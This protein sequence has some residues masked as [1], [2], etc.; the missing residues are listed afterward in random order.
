MDSIYVYFVALPGNVNEMV[1][2]C[3]DGYT[4][5]IDVSLSRAEQLDAYRHAMAHIKHNDFARDLP[6]DQ[7]ER[8]RHATA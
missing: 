4:V 6:V 3:A 7:I 1:L 5:Y 2:P 8:D